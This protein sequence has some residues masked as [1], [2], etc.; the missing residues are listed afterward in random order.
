MQTDKD[1]INRIKETYSMEPRTNFVLNTELQ[2]RKAARK[3]KRKRTFKLISL[4]SSGFIL[5]IIAILWIISFN[6]KE[7]IGNTLSSF[8]E[9]KPISAVK[10]NEPLVYI[11]HSHNQESFTSETKTKY[12]DNE[13]YHSS[14]NISLVGNRFS[15]ALKQRNIS[16]V[17]D[18]SDTM[19]IVQE[20][21]LSFDQSYS[22]SRE[23]LEENLKNNP[24]IEMIFD[25][26][27]DS[28]KKN[29]TTTKINGEDFARIK[30]VVF[31]SNVKDDGSLKFAQH[32]HKIA[33][34]KY[35]GLSS[36][37][38]VKTNPNTQNTYNLD[39]KNQSVLME[40]G[41]VENTL[42]EEYRTADAL[43]EIV[44]ELLKYQK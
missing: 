9:S 31:R 2:L 12:P 40:I 29:A 4:T 18:T 19:G 36:G 35:P 5:S 10:N 1:L 25:I 33:E 15:Q 16:S 8:V 44:E 32:L 28:N 7:N 26:H 13:H 41:G 34:E 20:R 3:M 14:R 30:F 23:F 42:E 17:H 24:S 11:Y 37:I 39:L 22:V 21:G 27:R 6:G 43:A 38:F